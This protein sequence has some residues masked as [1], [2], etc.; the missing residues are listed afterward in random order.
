MPAFVARGLEDADLVDA[1]EARPPYQRNDYLGWIG[2]AKRE[3]TKLR[4]FAQ[5]LDELRSGDIYMKMAWRRGRGGADDETTIPN[6]STN[7]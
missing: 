3:E 7:P 2:R 6:G 4:R 5:M 1:Y